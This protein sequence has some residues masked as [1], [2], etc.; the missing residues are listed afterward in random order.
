MN[1]F[2]KAGI[3]KNEVKKQV[4]QH[5]G[6]NIRRSVPY[7]PSTS[8][9]KI[10]DSLDI[11][12][13][14]IILME[15]RR[16]VQQSSADNSL[17]GYDSLG[18]YLE[19]KSKTKKTSVF[20]YDRKQCPRFD[21]SELISWLDEPSQSDVYDIQLDKLCFR[22]NDDVVH[23]KVEDFLTNIIKEESDE[24]EGWDKGAFKQ[25]FFVEM[26]SSSPG[27]DAVK[28][29]VKDFHPERYF[30]R[31][32]ERD[33]NGEWGLGMKIRTMDLEGIWS[34][35]VKQGKEEI[36][37]KTGAG[38]KENWTLDDLESEFI[39]HVSEDSPNYGLVNT[40]LMVSLLSR[41]FNDPID[42]KQFKWNERE[43]WV[44]V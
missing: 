43:Q 35:R 15:G 31:G 38:R 39:N 22:L 26:K 37:V 1:L 30:I 10:I 5:G 41:S 32:S 19:A 12:D 16:E 3:S 20:K 23:Q 42:D 18:S 21:S 14:D 27:T 34:L 4:Q 36:V 7:F 11:P 6:G 44:Q 8:A 33:Q 13:K 40:P 17:G 25:P 9:R 24:Y 28:K 2:E 29:V